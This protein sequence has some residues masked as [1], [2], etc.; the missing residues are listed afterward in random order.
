MPAEASPPCAAEALQGSSFAR[1]GEGPGSKVVRAGGVE[2]PTFGSV[3]RRSVQLSY[4]RKVHDESEKDQA[5]GMAETEGFE[6]S[7]SF[8]NLHTISNRAPSAT[9]TRL[10]NQISFERRRRR[11][12]SNPRSLS[13]R[14]FSRPLPSTA[15]PHLQASLRPMV[16]VPDCV[17]AALAPDRRERTPFSARRQLRQ[18]KSAGLTASAKESSRTTSKT[19]SSMGPIPRR[20]RPPAAGRARPRRPRPAA[21]TTRPT[22]GAARPRPRRPPPAAEGKARRGR[23]GG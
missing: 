10:R 4:A 5:D 1:P 7:V 22:S 6:P 12:D 9:R 23:R 20:R 15:R 2:P 3:V 11:W 8:L 17:A 14:R 19:S 13:G 21:P 18:G 16:L